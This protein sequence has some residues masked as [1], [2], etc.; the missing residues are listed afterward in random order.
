V[1]EDSTTTER[2]RFN[3]G[4]AMIIVV[5][6]ATGLA[7][8]RVALYQMGGW[9]SMIRQLGSPGWP[10]WWNMFWTAVQILFCFIVALIPALIVVCL[11]RPRPPLRRVALQPGFV[12]LCV[13]VLVGMIDVDAIYLDLV[14]WPPLV[15]AVLPGAAV[16]ASWLVLVVFRCWQPERSWIDRTGRLIGVFWIATIP[17]AIFFLW[18]VI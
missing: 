18:H 2:R 3:I 17:W 4:D 5:A 14:S 7:L 1:D 13:L 8:A 16:L 6:L 9:I 11:R 10:T 15:H 12:A